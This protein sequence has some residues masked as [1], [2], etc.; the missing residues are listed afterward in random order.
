MR[1]LR[2]CLLLAF[3]EGRTIALH[4]LFGECPV[5]IY[6]RC[7]HPEAVKFTLSVPLSNGSTALDL[8]PLDPELPA[9]FNPLIPIKM[10]VHGYGGLEVDTSTSN[11]SKAYQDVGYNVI[12]VDWKQLAQIPCYTTAYLNTWYVGQCISI[13]MVSLVPLG[14]DPTRIHV[15]GF[16]LGAHV[17][18]LAGNNLQK[19]LGTSFYRITG[20]DPALPFFATLKNDWKLDKSDADFV[21]VIHTSAGTFGKV[22]AT[23]HVDFYVNGGSLQPACQSRKYPPL[24]SHI[25]AGLYFAE[26]IRNSL[27]GGN[28]FIARKC[29]NVAH[30]VLGLCNSMENMAIMG[31]NVYYMTRGTYYLETGDQPPYALGF[32]SYRNSQK[33]NSENFFQQLDKKFKEFFKILC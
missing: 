17:S 25:M 7:I 10:V 29:D 33:S 14:V 20:L 4:L 3:L 6:E 32:K 15:V 1:C 26:S 8:D 13:L 16:S 30:Y 2:I 28:S 19:A 5:Y 23:G 31:E 18:G 11:V 12:I 22:E 21:D 9:E 24:C 27:S